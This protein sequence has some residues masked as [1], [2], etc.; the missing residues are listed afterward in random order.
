[1]L[2]NLGLQTDNIPWKSIFGDSRLCDIQEDP[3]KLDLNQILRQK[4]PETTSARHKHRKNQDDLWKD[5]GDGRHGC[6]VHARGLRLHVWPRWLH[7]SASLCSAH[8][9]FTPRPCQGPCRCAPQVAAP[10]LP[11]QPN[12]HTKRTVPA[13]HLHV[14]SDRGCMHTLCPNMGYHGPAG[15]CVNN[16]NYPGCFRGGLYVRP[17][18]RPS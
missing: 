7:S 3:R 6:L 17:E 8:G 16:I 1:M 18:A 12:N 10:S 14:S 4:L 5:R 15:G 11:L 2:V 9:G 13:S